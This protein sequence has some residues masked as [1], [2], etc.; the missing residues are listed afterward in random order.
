MTEPVE[1]KP[2]G[3]DEKTF[4][5][6]MHLA[7]LA[8]FVVPFAG[9]VLPIVM[10]ATNREESAQVDAHGKVILNWI[11]SLLIYSVVAAAL[12]FLIIGGFLL[13]A[14][15][16]VNVVFIVI[17]AVKANEGVVW[18]YPGSIRFLK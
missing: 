17:G 18:A 9:L 5:L 6:L 1:P 4:C 13:L 7:Q 12:V 11:L 2:W 10:W 15:M 14:L 8:G 3:M 16:L